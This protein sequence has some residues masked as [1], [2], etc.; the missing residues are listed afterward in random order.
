MDG[1]QA[2]RSPEERG[3]RVLLTTLEIDVEIKLIGDNKEVS[4]I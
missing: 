4:S 1:A 3:R 2:W